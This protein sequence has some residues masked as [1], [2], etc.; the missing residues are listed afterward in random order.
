[1]QAIIENCRSLH[2]HSGLYSLP[3]ERTDL[4]EDLAISAGYS[5]WIQRAG[6]LLSVR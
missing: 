1:M 4:I 6:A 3:A 5:I 2:P